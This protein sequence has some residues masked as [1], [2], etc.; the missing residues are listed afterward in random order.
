MMFPRSFFEWAQYLQ[1]EIRKAFHMKLETI[2][3]KSAIELS[4][5]IIL[6]A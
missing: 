4:V 2:V 5:S 3:K 6:L 1:Y